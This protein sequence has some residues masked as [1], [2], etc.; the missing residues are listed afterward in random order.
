MLLLMW[1]GIL[2]NFFGMFI[3]LE[4]LIFGVVFGYFSLWSFYW[5]FKLLMKKE[6]MGYGDFKLL[7]VLGVWMGW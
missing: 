3:I 5:L 1:L 6:G 7:V 2:L 4:S